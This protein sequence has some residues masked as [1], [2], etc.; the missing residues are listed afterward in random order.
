LVADRPA[1]G[2]AAEP[3]AVK[4]LRPPL[5][6]YAQVT[7]VVVGVLAALALLWSARSVLV[8]VFLA[9]FL[10]AGLDPVVRRIE[11]VVPRHGWAVLVL[12]LGLL[13]VAVALLTIVLRPAVKELSQLAEA[14]PSLLDKA[15][16][17][18]QPLGEFLRQPQCSSRCRTSCG[19]CRE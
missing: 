6:H 2:S 5:I 19:S 3:T 14:L 11:R 10:A 9:I 16:S 15:T 13:V 8:A 12:V 18:D 4:V 7:L 1:S 17:P